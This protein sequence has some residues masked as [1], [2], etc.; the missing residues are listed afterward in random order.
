MYMHMS[1][2]HG[3][4]IHIIIVLLHRKHEWNKHGTCSCELNTQSKYFGKGLDLYENGL[5]FGDI[6]KNADIRPSQNND[7]SVCNSHCYNYTALIKFSLPMICLG[8][9]H[10][11][12]F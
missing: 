2:V 6:L 11:R 9:G 12:C 3:Y 1:K 5:N 8:T 10:T 4:I 7:Y